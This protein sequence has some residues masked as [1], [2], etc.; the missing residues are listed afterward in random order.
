[1]EILWNPR[2]GNGGTRV[3]LWWNPGG[4]LVEPSWNLTSGRPDRGRSGARWLH[5][6][7][8]RLVAWIGGLLPGPQSGFD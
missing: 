4:T 7:E 6:P 3:E 1:M 8:Q 2:L 5:V